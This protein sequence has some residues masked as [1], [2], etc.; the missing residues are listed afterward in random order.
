MASAYAVATHTYPEKNP[1]QKVTL[2]SRW[3]WKVTVPRRGGGKQNAL[4]TDSSGGKEPEEGSPQVAAEKWLAKAGAVWWNAELG[5]PPGLAAFNE[6]NKAMIAA[7][8]A[9]VDRRTLQAPRQLKLTVPV[10]LGGGASEDFVIV[11]EVIGQP[12]TAADA[13][14]KVR[15]RAARLVRAAAAAPQSAPRAADP[16]TACSR[17]RPPSTRRCAR[18]APSPRPPPTTGRPRAS[19]CAA[20]RLPTPPPPPPPPAPPAPLLSLTPRRA[21]A[22]HRR[23][24]CST[25]SSA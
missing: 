22:P 14:L 3:G 19:T 23:S 8:F 21:T 10:Q 15:R 17:R 16:R 2:P 7:V 24:T 13:A 18:A 6:Q 5:V 1:Q 9:G 25:V 11:L 20:T 12:P 4:Y